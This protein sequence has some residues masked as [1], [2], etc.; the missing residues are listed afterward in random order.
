MKKLLS[1][2]LFPIMVLFFTLSFN[3]YIA[4]AEVEHSNDMEN[5]FECHGYKGENYVDKDV[6]ESSVHGGQDCIT[7]HDFTDANEAGV[8]PEVEMSENCG[9]CHSGSWSD[10]QDSV[11]IES[12]WAPSCADC[13][14][15]HEITTVNNET[16]PAYF[17]N[18]QES[19][20]ECHSEAAAS[21]Q[22]HFHGKAVALGSTSN[23]SCTD[24]HGAH[25][26]LDS[27]N[28]A[29]LTSR[30]NTPELCAECHK[31]G[32]VIGASAAPQHYTL[33]PEGYS[34][35]MYWVK[36]IFMLLIL[37]VVGFFLIHILFDLFR[38]LR[39]IRS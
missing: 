37:V 28:P 38:R 30:Q 8:I 35:P 7:C 6:Y 39:N 5:C 29:S 3:V 25:T 1:F 19:C 33:E 2:I 9:T 20:G 4:E 31:S 14:G 36:K 34:A 26:I 16:S 21:Y 17:Q 22:E 13:H 12:E 18:Q 24:C 32:E 23:P 27:D 11:H 10:Y 15:T